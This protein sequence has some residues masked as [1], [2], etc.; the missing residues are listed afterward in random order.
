[1][2]NNQINEQFQAASKDMMETVL[3]FQSI[4][5][6]AMQRLAQQ[7]FAFAA[8]A[9]TASMKQMQALA[10]VK[11]MKEAVEKQSELATDLAGK[12]LDHSKQTWE[13]L[14]ESKNELNTLVEKNLNT[15]FSI[16]TP[17]GK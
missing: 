9:M 3:L 11:D 8:D 13:V 14:T 16:T 10:G 15:A 7:Q 4:N 17:A 2:E 5:E 1:M 12:I 6:K